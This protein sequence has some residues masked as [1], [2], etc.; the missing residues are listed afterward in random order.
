[1]FPLGI[2]PHVAL[3]LA[4]YHQADVRA[5]FPRKPRRAFFPVRRVP[6]PGATAIPR[7]P[8]PRQPESQPERQ[9]ERQP[10]TA[11]APRVTAA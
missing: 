10:E 11:T 1:M 3:T 8:E 4:E 9:P 2:D 7:V 6:G 5:S